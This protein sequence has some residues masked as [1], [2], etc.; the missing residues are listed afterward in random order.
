MNL[1][2]E[3]ATQKIFDL[4]S[5][6]DL[7]IHTRLKLVSIANDIM[8]GHAEYEEQMRELRSMNSCVF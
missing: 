8:N 6:Q 4:A 1:R 3:N 2:L 7:P 5:E